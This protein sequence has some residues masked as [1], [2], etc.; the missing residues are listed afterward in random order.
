M[1]SASFLTS[2][3]CEKYNTFINLLHFY[4]LVLGFY[5]VYFHLCSMCN[6]SNNIHIQTIT[7]L[8][9][10][11]FAQSTNALTEQGF[12]IYESM[13]QLN[14]PSLY[15][16]QKS[17][18]YHRFCIAMIVCLL[19][20]MFGV[21]WVMTF[22]C[23]HFH[24]I[25]LQSISTFAFALDSTPKYYSHFHWGLILKFI[26]ISIGVFQSLG[27][28][29]KYFM[30]VQHLNPTFAHRTQKSFHCHLFIL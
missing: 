27:S 13:S 8:D 16:K 26:C 2:Y 23:L 1:P 15:S 7:F 14:Q 29:P 25:L 11:C 5:F 30:H 6:A 3:F 22:Q 21:V 18:H 4:S 9:S 17:F 20:C 19:H 10:L 12:S 24:W 28:T